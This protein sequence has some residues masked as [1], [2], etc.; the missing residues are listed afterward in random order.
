MLG[1]QMTVRLFEEVDQSEQRLVRFKYEVMTKRSPYF[2]RVDYI[3]AE[4]GT[5]LRA[6]HTYRVRVNRDT[7]APRV[8]RVLAE[9]DAGAI[10]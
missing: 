7:R 6:G 9:V 5:P 1:Q 4:R 2:G 8:A 10:Q 3:W